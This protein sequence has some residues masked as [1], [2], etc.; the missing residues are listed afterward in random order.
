[1]RSINLQKT[2]F[3][4]FDFLFIISWKLTK[5]GSNKWLDVHRQT[6]TFVDTD[7][8]PRS[9]YFPALSGALKDSSTAPKVGRKLSF[10]L[11]V[12]FQRRFGYRDM[13]PSTFRMRGNTCWGC[14]PQLTIPPWLLHRRSTPSSCGIDSTKWF[15]F[16]C[17]NRRSLNFRRSHSSKDFRAASLDTSW[18]CWSIRIRPIL[19]NCCNSTFATRWF[20]PTNFDRSQLADVLEFFLRLT[21]H[22]LT[23]GNFSPAQVLNCWNHLQSSL[24]C[25]CSKLSAWSRQTF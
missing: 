4:L 9:R 7:R 16:W 25:C 3:K 5:Q 2:K 8:L 10:D 21:N 11:W 12:G 20:D 17:Q 6:S 24:A 19:S 22:R 1:M 23:S 15:E 14:C 18:G 13:A